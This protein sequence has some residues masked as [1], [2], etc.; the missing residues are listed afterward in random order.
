MKSRL[1]IIIFALLEI[2]I[3]AA[4]LIAVSLSLIKGSSTKPPEVLTFVLVTAIISMTLGFGLLKCNLTC[5]HF[6]IYFSS[7]II[8]SK[9][10][11]FARVITLSGALETAIP[12]PLK[13]IISIFYHSLLIFYFTREPIKKQFG[14]CH[15]VIFSLKLPFKND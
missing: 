2:L 8:L 6:L 14:E 5:Y 4:T 15:K 11:I 12:S 13:N 7:I 10:L 3:G 1:G 9:V